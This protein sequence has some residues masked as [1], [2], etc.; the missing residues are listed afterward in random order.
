[1]DIWKAVLPNP[2]LTVEYE[3]LVTNPEATMRQ[4]FQHI[5]LDW[6]PA[7]LEMR[8]RKHFSRLQACCRFGAR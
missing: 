6:D 4:V 1:M 8:D 2:M 5:N 3:E 7:C